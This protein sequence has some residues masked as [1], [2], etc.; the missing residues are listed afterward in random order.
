V[1][2]CLTDALL[3][4]SSFE[5]PQMIELNRLVQ[6]LRQGM[7]DAGAGGQKAGGSAGG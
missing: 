7:R 2:H 6:A 5:V 4:H 1:S 3:R